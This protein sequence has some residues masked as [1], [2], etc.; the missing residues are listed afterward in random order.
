MALFVSDMPDLRALRA[1]GLESVHNGLFDRRVFERESFARE[2]RRHDA[3]SAQQCFIGH[4]AE[5]QTQ[6]MAGRREEGWAMK[7]AAEG[8][9]E[10]AIAYRIR[11]GDVVDAACFVAIDGPLDGAQHVVAID[12]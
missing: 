3:L 4:L 12:P 2:A 6:R 7:R 5:Q 1:R 11:R 9:G 10:V 8:A